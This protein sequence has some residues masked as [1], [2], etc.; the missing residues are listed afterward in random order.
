[1]SKRTTVSPKRFVGLYS[2]AR[3]K[4]EAA[5]KLGMSVR[6]V[7]QRAA[8]Y[9]RLGVNLPLLPRARRGGV[10]VDE[11]NALVEKKAKPKE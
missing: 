8:A 3:S 4:E 6:R 5:A 1:M 10:D 11:L 7:T 9:R 2:S